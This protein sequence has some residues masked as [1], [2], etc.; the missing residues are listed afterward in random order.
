MVRKIYAVYFE[1]F[2]CSLEIELCWCTGILVT[3]FSVLDSNVLYLGVFLYT[4]SNVSNSQNVVQPQTTACMF[5]I[6]CDND[7]PEF[8]NKINI[9]SATISIVCNINAHVPLHTHLH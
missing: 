2:Y 3:V 5:P 4:K 9:C 6:L 7:M 1:V 8:D